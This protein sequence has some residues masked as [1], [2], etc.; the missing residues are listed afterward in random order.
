MAVDT[1]VLSNQ[2]SF[3]YAMNEFGDYWYTIVGLNPSSAKPVMVV[4]NDKDDNDGTVYRLP[5]ELVAEHVKQ[6]ATRKIS[7]ELKARMPDN[8]VVAKW[9]ELPKAPAKANAA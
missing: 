4:C 1:D 5:A 6:M 3:V 8:G 7:E 9:T 2:N